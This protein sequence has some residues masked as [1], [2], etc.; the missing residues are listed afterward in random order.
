[1]HGNICGRGWIGVE[2][3][4]DDLDIFAT[5]IQV[6]DVDAAEIMHDPQSRQYDLSDAQYLIRRRQISRSLARLYWPD[7]EYELSQYYNE[8]DSKHQS[9]RQQSVHRLSI[10]KRYV[11]ILECYYRVYELRTLMFDA[12]AGLVHDVTDLPPEQVIAIARL[13]PNVEIIRKKRQV[14]KYARTA[15]SLKGVTLEADASPYDDNYFP[16]VPYFA[17]HTRDL[18]FGIPYQIMDAQRE[19]N[20]GDTQILHYI[21]NLPKTKVITDNPEDADAFEQGRDITVLKGNYKIIEPPQ[22]P[23]AFAQRS[24][25]GM[26]K[27]KRISGISD[28]L[29]GLR[30]GGDSGVVVDIRRQQSLA[31]ISSL[32]D[33]LQW[34]A[35]NISRLITSRIRQFMS[36]EHIGRVLGQKATPELVTVL[37]R[38]D[39]ETYDFAI[40][41]SPSSPTMRAENWAKI[42]DLMTIMP[43]PPDIV[44]EAS[45]VVQK[46]QLLAMAKEAQEKQ[47]QLQQL[48]AGGGLNQNAA[49]PQVRSAV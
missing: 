47:A 26:D 24:D 23:L 40:A 30:A 32:F 3:V 29:R 10:L 38:L 19:I 41:Q 46:D 28:D 44:I 43:L 35:E 42:K 22:F 18:D 45:D 27:A 33:N 15:G 7:K 36:E 1:L 39:V 2:Q 12:E 4:E 8:Y 21:N 9:D 48:P 25:R 17:Y 37:K 6:R 5:K 14:M 20:K 49:V 31:N 16:Y 11:E 13:Y 34:M